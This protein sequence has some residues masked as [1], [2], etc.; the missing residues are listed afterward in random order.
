MSALSE[1]REIER[2]LPGVAG[3]RLNGSI[4]DYYR[5]LLVCLDEEQRK[6]NPDTALIAVLCDAV[7]FTREHLHLVS[8]GMIE[9]RS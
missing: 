6:L 7:R 8:A 9:A 3:E 2:G 5:R 1:L 4:S